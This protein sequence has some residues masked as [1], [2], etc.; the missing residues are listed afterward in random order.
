M[1]DQIYSLLLQF[2]ALCNSLKS[3]PPKWYWLHFM[4]RVTSKE[5]SNCS[6]L[7]LY[8]M[9][10]EE[11]V[12]FFFFNS[13]PSFKPIILCARN[14]TFW[15]CI[16][17]R[18]NLILSLQ[19]VRL[20]VWPHFGPST[21]ETGHM[22]HQPMSNVPSRTFQYLMTTILSKREVQQ[23]L[24]HTTILPLVALFQGSCLF[25][26]DYYTVWQSSA[27]TGPGGDLV[28]THS[29]IDQPNEDCPSIVTVEGK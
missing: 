9:Q 6:V 22:S 16:K 5:K 1:L 21:S 27:D 11:R 3:I 29:L 12:K 24:E 26:C 25:G 17:A 13:R 19:M 18:G 4:T 14:V 10:A 20:L 8:C 23:S 2:N 7:V 15:Q 28:I